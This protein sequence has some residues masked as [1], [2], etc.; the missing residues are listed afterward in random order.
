MDE[1]KYENI[2]ETIDKIF[3][4]DENAEAETE[5][6]EAETESDKS[7]ESEDDDLE[8]DED[9]DIVIPDDDSTEEGEEAE[10]DEEGRE[11][12]KE[13]NEA[14]PEE[15]DAR[16]SEISRLKAELARYK[17]QAKETA[18]KLGVKIEGEDVL[19]GLVKLAAEAED[20]TPE[21]YLKKKAEADELEAAKQLI[22][23]Q[24]GEAIRRADLEELHRL[25]PETS[26]YD[27]ILKL[28]YFN[29][30][31]EL[32]GGG[33]SVKE[34]YGASHVD[35][36]ITYAAEKAKKNTLAGTKNHLQTSVPKGAKNDEI[37]MTRQE[38][39]E[40]RE[41]FSDLSDAEIIALRK[42]VK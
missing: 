5:I 3:E 25:F 40:M 32:R 23:K 19:G 37:A 16:D 36:I 7:D 20:T 34:A 42:R 4:E 13:G 29:R 38:L 27:D 41:A 33:L 9:G 1:M 18:E 11:D 21:E 2:D 6:E 12:T 30:F 14:K 17:S 26:E 22:A 10:A 28:P 35:T 24:K 39:S 15:A 31:G 8:Y